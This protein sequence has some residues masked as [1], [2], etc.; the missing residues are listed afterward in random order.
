MYSRV[1]FYRRYVLDESEEKA[2]SQPLDPTL[3]MYVRY[4]FV[5]SDFGQLFLARLRLR[6]EIGR[7]LW[8]DKIVEYLSKLISRL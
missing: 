1:L 6:R 5:E 4:Y 8:L 2:R 7:A 3:E